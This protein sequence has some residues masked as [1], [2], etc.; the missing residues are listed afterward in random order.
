[1]G[2]AERGAREGA[3]ASDTFFKPGYCVNVSKGDLSLL[4]TIL[5]RLNGYAQEV[6]PSGYMIQHY[7]KR[8]FRI[9]SYHRLVILVLKG[10]KASPNDVI[11][12]YTVLQKYVV[13]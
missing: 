5:I 4:Q 10:L 11:I 3:K 9:F 6:D 13:Y 1:M 7:I 8:G 12:G 2:V